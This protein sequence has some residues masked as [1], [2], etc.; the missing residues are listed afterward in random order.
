MSESVSNWRV[1]G[2]PSDG[3]VIPFVP[4]GHKTMTVI[5]GAEYVVRHHDSVLLF[6]G[7]DRPELASGS[8]VNHGR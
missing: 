6:K 7:Y 4:D 2:G 3:R 8:G 5:E 1:V